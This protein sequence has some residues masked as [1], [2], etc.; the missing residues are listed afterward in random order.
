MGFSFL[1]WNIRHFQARE[2]R[3]RQVRDTIRSFSPDVFGI[4]EFQGKAQ[5]RRLAMDFFHDYDFS[6]T[7]SKMGL[8]I[9]IGC[10]KSKFEQIVYT[11][12]RTLQVGN[13]NLRPGGIV[14]VRQK[15]SQRFDNL[16]FL[17]T[18]SGRSKKDYNNRQKM[19]R[20]IW[21]MKK[22]IESLPIQKNK[23]RLI[24]LGDLNTMGKS[25]SDGTKSISAKDEIERLT[26][27]AN[28]N[29]MRILSKSHEKTWSNRNSSK[30]SNLDHV[31]ASNDL[32]FEKLYF[33][34]EPNKEF[35]L[36]VT[37]WNFFTGNKRK[38]FIKNISD[39]CL[40]YGIVSN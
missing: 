21:D 31:I 25:G 32:H 37:G 17:H 4:L 12:R 7:D 33:P 20:K 16:L 11:Q 34:R 1:V 18:D 9:L 23:A 29:K 3:T 2:E 26:E 6:F 13:I 39:H 24:A 35:E 15:N 5:A 19:F 28:R 10:R 8:E 27:D 14:S 36:E 40:L 30:T 22:T 38:D